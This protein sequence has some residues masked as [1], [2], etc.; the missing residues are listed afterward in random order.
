[1]DNYYP[2]P[3]QQYYGEP[4]K[5]KSKIHNHF[6]LLVVIMLGLT[7][8][9]TAWASWI[10]S[11]H[12]GNQTANFALSNNLTAEGNAEYS[13]GLQLMMS[14][15]VLHDRLVG[16]TLDRVIAGERE[17]WDAYEHLML[18]IEL[19]IFERVSDE[20]YYAIIWADEQFELGL[21]LGAPITPFMNED[22]LATY[23]GHAN[24]LQVRAHMALSAAESDGANA[25]AYGL[26]SV[27]YTVALFLFGI[28]NTFKAESKK[29]VVFFTASGAFIIATFYMLF[30]PLPTGF[31]FFNFFG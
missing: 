23:F 21:E 19:I 15:M 26:V 25:D 10:G 18:R 24:R 5:K 29:L 9:L 11:L 17:D 20:L 22:L 27:F 16:Y 28:A 14:D 31:S 2:M 6:E 1:M 3:P 4:K 30:L 13:M 8:L 12:G 7:A